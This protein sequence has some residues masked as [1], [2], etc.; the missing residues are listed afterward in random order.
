MRSTPVDS[1]TALNHVENLSNCLLAT[2]KWLNTFFSLEAFPTTSFLH[3]SL[4]TFAQLS[5]CIVVTFRLCT[6]DHPDIPWDRQRL[7]YYLLFFHD[8]DICVR[9]Y[10]NAFAGQCER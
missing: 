4:A 8:W 1:E 2:K 5:H 7:V 9:L 10:T 6:F 3:L